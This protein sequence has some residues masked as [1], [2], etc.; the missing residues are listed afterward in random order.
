MREDLALKNLRDVKEILDRAG[1]RYWLDGGT[2][3]GAVRDGKF[4]PWDDDIDLGTLS[5]SMDKI[6]PLFPEFQKKRFHIS[7]N[8]YYLKFTRN[9]IKVDISTYQIQD[10]YARIVWK[11]MW[12]EMIRHTLRIIENALTY[13]TYARLREVLF[14]WVSYLKERSSSK[15][16]PVSVPKHYYERLG[17]IEF[18]EMKFNTPFPVDSYLELRFGKDWKI[19]R[20]DWTYYRDDGTVVRKRDLI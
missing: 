10:E 18:Y 13:K 7:F 12:P 8:K 16:Y 20:K 11:I 2:L 5:S 14:V 19:P 6:I 3:L 15:F 9:S 17:H 1:V 4:I